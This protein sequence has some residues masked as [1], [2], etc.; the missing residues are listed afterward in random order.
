M[1]IKGRHTSSQL[2]ISFSLCLLATLCCNIINPKRQVFE[3][4]S[5]V[6]IQLPGRAIT[7][8]KWLHN[9]LSKLIPICLVFYLG[10]C[11]ALLCGRLFVRS[12]GLNVARQ[13]WFERCTAHV[14]RRQMQK[15]VCKSAIARYFISASDHASLCGRLCLSAS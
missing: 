4:T 14:A 11:H 6:S 10:I 7:I 5:I 8:F 1:R 13:M 15:T 3:I 2:L 12:C 9:H